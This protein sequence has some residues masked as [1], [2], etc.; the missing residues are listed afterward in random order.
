VQRFRLVQLRLAQQSSQLIVGRV[1]LWVG[2]SAVSR[3][4]QSQNNNDNNNNSNSKVSQQ[5]L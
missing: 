3:E 2:D 1:V 5:T 4:E